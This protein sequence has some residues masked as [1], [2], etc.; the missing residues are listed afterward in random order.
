[1]VPRVVYMLDALRGLLGKPLRINSGYRTPEH[2]KAVGGAS[3]SGHVTG[4][5]VDISTRGWTKADRTDLIL[6]A[7]KLG[8][9]GIGIA[10]TFIHI[11]MKARTASW[12]YVGG[13]FV[14]HALA[15]E[16]KFV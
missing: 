1:M 9:T 3:G 7:R 2:N 13:R 8:F 12:H 10:S 15:D 16:L 14:S 4:E 6:Y 11:D 5:A